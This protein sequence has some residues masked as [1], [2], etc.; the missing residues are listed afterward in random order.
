MS[1]QDGRTRLDDGHMNRLLLSLWFD[2]SSSTF[3]S[4]TATARAKLVKLFPKAHMS[5]TGRRT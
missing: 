4:N 2:E 1:F 3:A 5:N